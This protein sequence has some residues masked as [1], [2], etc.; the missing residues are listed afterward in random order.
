MDKDFLASRSIGHMHVEHHTLYSEDTTK[1][2][3]CYWAGCLTIKRQRLFQD[4][5]I[6]IMLEVGMA[7]MKTEEKS[8]KA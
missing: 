2:P 1:E 6:G 4:H 7:V 5:F 3:A 8:L